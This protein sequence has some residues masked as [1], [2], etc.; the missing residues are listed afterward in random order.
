VRVWDAD[1]GAELACLRGHEIHVTSVSWSPD[2]RRL[3][4][5]AYDQTVRVWDA[6]SGAELACL[7]GH[8]CAVRS[9][10]W[11]PDGRRLVCG[12]PDGRRLASR[13]EDWTVRVWDA[14]SGD[15]LEVIQGQDDVA[16]I[17]K[18]LGGTGEFPW[19]ALSRRD[20]TVIEPA[21]GGE[22]IAWFPAQLDH[23]TTHPSGRVWAGKVENHLYIIQLEGEVSSARAQI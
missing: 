1:S 13:S 2:G 18:G 20:E 4:S 17:A 22:P 23:I 3:A 16:A 7:R 19:R 21:V 14:D 15:C 6:A 5:G 11:A 8:E 9:V 10:S 12:A